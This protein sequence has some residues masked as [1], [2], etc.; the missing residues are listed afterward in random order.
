MTVVRL[1]PKY[2]GTNKVGDQ[3]SIILSNVPIN[4]W[5]ITGNVK[6]FDLG[7]LPSTVKK[8]MV[9]KVDI[10]MKDRLKF[11]GKNFQVDNIDDGKLEGLYEIQISQ[12]N[13][14]TVL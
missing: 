10:R 4:Q 12:D 3:E 8:L 9:G 2:V 13:R 7:L 5:D 6:Q 1:V 14:P 11:D